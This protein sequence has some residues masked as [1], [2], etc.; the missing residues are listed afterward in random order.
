MFSQEAHQLV[1]WPIVCKLCCLHTLI[2]EHDIE[3]LATVTSSL[4]RAINIKIKHTHRFYLFDFSTASTNEQL[5]DANLQETYA[6]I[7][8]STHKDDVTIGAEFPNSSDLT[9]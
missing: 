1:R 4:H 8:L 7:T 6:L 9:G 2:L 3:K 5:L